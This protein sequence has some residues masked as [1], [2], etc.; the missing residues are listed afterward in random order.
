[1]KRIGKYIVRGWLGRGGMS[2]VY[3]VE[4]P[5]IGKIVALKRLD[6]HPLLTRLMGEA[7][8]RDLFVS[9]ALKLA[10]L[11][12][13]N[14]VAIRDF[15]EADGGLFYT[16]DYFFSNL[17]Q[18]IG[19][20]RHIE[21]PS[22]TIRLDRA[23]DI[24]RQALTGLACLHHHGIV[25][26]DI[27]PFNLL[28]DDQNVVKISDFGL[29][30]LRGEAS[31]APQHLKVGSPWYAAPEQED[32]PDSADARSDLYAIGV[33]FYR[34]LT[35][36]LPAD[37][38]QPPAEFNSDLDDSWNQFILRGIAR[39]PTLRYADALEMLDA[40]H[41]LE[42][43]WRARQAKICLLPEAESISAA[44]PDPQTYTLRSLPIK[45]DPGRAK[46]QFKVDDQWRPSCYIVNRF[47]PLPDGTVRDSF[48]GLIWQQA[49]CRYS[50]SWRDAH[51]YVGELNR[52]RFAARDGWRLP[53]TPEL[54]SLLRPTPHG[55]DFCVEP[56]FDA[57]QKT[58]WSSD[59]RSFTAA[60]FA[61]SEMGFI[62][63]RDV[64]GGCF[65]RA[66][67]HTEASAGQ[68]ADASPL[69]LSRRRPNPSPAAGLS[70]STLE[71]PKERGSPE[72]R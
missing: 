52:V 66:V 17:G 62:G 31:S 55:R 1:M 46:I 51:A 67:C 15:D 22:R 44:G 56:L 50:M 36:T 7:K 35:G 38:P 53:T 26:R 18:L 2:K 32:S 57:H 34:M 3:K 19:E 37:P 58:L 63:W 61:N 39:V 33:T 72:H 23:I 25:H 69:T 68:A 6:P 64:S 11:N 9:E 49:G 59:R 10:R 5:R 48:A 20:T 70:G 60:W 47:S 42:H 41:A 13:P 30:S 24:M 8:I 12:H 14:I 43:D 65:V 45:I 27:K 40:L 21:E 28:F 54:M 4:I 29:S 71:N 16:M